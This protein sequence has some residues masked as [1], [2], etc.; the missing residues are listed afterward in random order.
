MSIAWAV[1]NKNVN[2]A[3]PKLARSRISAAWVRR[4]AMSVTARS[5]VSPCFIRASSKAAPL[6]NGAPNRRSDPVSSCSNPSNSASVDS[7]FEYSSHLCLFRT[8][9][10]DDSRF[11]IKAMSCRTSSVGHHYYYYYDQQRKW[12]SKRLKKTLLLN[13]PPHHFHEVPLL[14]TKVMV[15]DRV[16]ADICESQRRRS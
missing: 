3:A 9:P 4:Q 15:D 14:Y 8:R 10:S 13:C 16:L 1:L 2:F 7:V 6:N 5:N 12:G 11:S